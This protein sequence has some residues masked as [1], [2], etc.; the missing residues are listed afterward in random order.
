MPYVSSHDYD[1]HYEITCPGDGPTLVLI[2]GI[3]EQIGSVEFPEEQCRTFAQRG[4]RVI[5]VDNRTMGLSQRRD[6]TAPEPFTRN[7]IADDIA[8]VIRD[9][10]DEPVHLL[11]ASMGGALV[12]WTA[13]LHPDL[14]STL[15]VVMAGASADPADTD[16]PQVPTEAI[17]LLTQ[18][19]VRRDRDAA[20]EWVIDMWRWIWGIGYPFE[21]DWVRQ[22]VTQAHDRAYNPEGIGLLLR[23]GSGSPYLRDEQRKITCPTLVIHGGEDPVFGPEHG[24]DIAANIDGATL[25][26][27]PRMGHIMH[28]EQW[29]EMADRVATLAG[30]PEPPTAS[31][32]FG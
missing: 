25:W 6:G 1:I 26:L 16:A 9:L 18:M 19:P 14:V 8:A 27:D 28:R 21:E 11:G 23:S 29:E 17:E 32:G 15:T 10:G 31:P 12:R 3:G 7:D 2:A 5:R 22:R 24:R 13:V 4:F 30:L 20:I